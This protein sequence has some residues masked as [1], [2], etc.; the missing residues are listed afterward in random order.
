MYACGVPCMICTSS[1][2]FFLGGGI[3]QGSGV[4]RS[5]TET[6]Q[7]GKYKL[8]LRLLVCCWVGG[9]MGS[10]SGRRACLLVGLGRLHTPL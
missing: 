10:G 9:L 5:V 8:D 3:Y 7:Q 2:F 1:V 6:G 4:C